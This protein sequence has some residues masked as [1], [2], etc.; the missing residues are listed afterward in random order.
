LG[1]VIDFTFTEL[2]FPKPALGLP[3]GCELFYDDMWLLAELL[4]AYLRSLDR[5]AT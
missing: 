3:E 1:L 5:R 2:A 4:E